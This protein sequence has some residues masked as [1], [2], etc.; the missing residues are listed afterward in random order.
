[1]MDSPSKFSFLDDEFGIK[2]GLFKDSLNE[3]VLF[4]K[5]VDNWSKLE[6]T[7]FETYP[8]FFSN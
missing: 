3:D 5:L 4:S 2:A 6:A 8:A 7:F 1:M